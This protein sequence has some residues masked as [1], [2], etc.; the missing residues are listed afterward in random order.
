[1]TA[2][3][4]PA[5]FGGI[6]FDGDIV[7][8][9]IEKPQIGEGWINGGF[10]VFEPEVLD[11]IE[12]DFSQL[13]KPIART[14]CPR[15]TTRRVSARRLLAMHGYDA[16]S[17]SAS[18]RCLTSARRRGGPGMSDASMPLQRSGETAPSSETGGA[19]LLGG[20]L[21]PSAWSSLKLTWWR[22]SAT[23][24]RDRG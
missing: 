21:N 20:W 23:G 6:V 3:R 16:R 2:V 10:L 8:E 11:M 17:A 7:Q 19:G 4:P 18:I 14:S 1:M 13:G 9:F 22:R 15:E 5:R 12:A 24:S